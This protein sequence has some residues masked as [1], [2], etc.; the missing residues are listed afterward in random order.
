MEPSAEPVRQSAHGRR[1]CPLPKDTPSLA[2]HSSKETQMNLTV[3]GRSWALA[4]LCLA[5]AASFLIG[6]LTDWS[7]A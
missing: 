1:G 2:A 4:A 6:L 7:M 3:R 5:Y